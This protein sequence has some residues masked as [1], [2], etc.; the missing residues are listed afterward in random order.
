MSRKRTYA[1]TVTRDTSYL[2]E[3]ENER[4]AEEKVM[5]EEL[6]EEI[7]NTTKKVLVEKWSS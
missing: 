5:L 1:V 3:A 7:D 4:E 2:V 6:G